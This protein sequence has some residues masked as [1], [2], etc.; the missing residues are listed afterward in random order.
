MQFLVDK[1]KESLTW[2]QWHLDNGTFPRDDYREI[3]ELI[4]VYL[5]GTVPGAFGP[6]RKGAMHDEIY[7]LNMELFSK[8]YLNT[9][10]TPP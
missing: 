8:E 7:M 10:W 4:V 2:A 9:S 6:K 3:N 1:A 5:G